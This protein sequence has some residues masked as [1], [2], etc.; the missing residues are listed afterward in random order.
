MDSFSLLRTNVALTS[1]FKIVISSDDNLY[2]ESFDSNTELSSTKYKKYNFNFDAKLETVLRNFYNNLSNEIVFGVKQSQDIQQMYNDF[3]Y[4]WDNFYSSGSS[5]VEDKS[6]SEEFEYFAPLY[7]NGTFPSNFIVFRI[8]GPG[9]IEL[10]KDN[11]K[12][13]IVDKLKCVKVFDLSSYSNIGK[14]LENNYTLNPSFPIAPIEID[15]RQ[16]EFTKWN[17]ID[18]YSGG[19]TSK[20]LFLDDFLKVNNGLYKFDKFLT[21]GW[22]NNGVVF[23][24]IL[25]LKYLFDDTPATPATVR[26]WSMNRYMGFYINDMEEVMNVTPFNSDKLSMD[27]VIGDNNY[28]INS[29][30]DYIDPILGGYNPTKTYWVEQNGQFYQIKKESIGWKVNSNISL[31]GMTYSNFNQHSVIIEEGKIKW[32]PEYR[33]DSFDLDDFD[34]YDVWLVNIDDKY[35]VVK[36]NTNGEYYLNTD[37][38]FESNRNL[39]IYYINQSDPSYTTRINLY[40]FDI[41]PIIFKIYRLKFTQINDIDNDIVNTDWSRFEYELVDNVTNTNEPKLYKADISSESYPP[42]FDIFT[43]QNEN[44]SIPVSSEYLSSNELFEKDIDSDN[45]S[46]LWYKSPVF[47]KWGAMNS[48]SNYDYPYRANNYA[49]IDSYNRTTDPYQNIPDKWARNLDYFYSI[50]PD[51]DSYDFTSV[52]I[53][54][55]EN[56]VVNTNFKFDASK[57]FNS[58]GWDGDYFT[59]F[60]GKKET[61]NGVSKNTH[62]YSSI[63]KSSPKLTG[64]TLFRGLKFNIWDVAN[65]QLDENNSVKNLNL[66]PSNNFGDWKFSVLL[67]TL[68]YDIDGEFSPINNQLSWANINMWSMGVTYSTN[69]Y[70][71]YN[72]VLYK[73]NATSYTDNP[74]DNPGSLSEWSYPTTIVDQIF[75]NPNSYAAPTYINNYGW[76]LKDDN[77]WTIK[78][79]VTF[80]N[81]STYNS[82]DIVKYSNILYKCSLDG[83]GATPSFSDV[84]WITLADWWDPDISYTTGQRVLAIDGNTYIVISSISFGQNPLSNPDTW[85]KEDVQNTYWTEVPMWENKSYQINDYTFYSGGLFRSLTSDNTQIPQPYITTTDWNFLY[86]TD[87]VLDK[88]YTIGNVVKWGNRYNICLNPSTYSVSS[89]LD[90]GV[91]IYINKK[92]NNI[93]VN[94]YCNDGTLN[95]IDNSNRQETLYSLVNQKYIASNFINVINNLNHKW[96]FI[97]NLNYY[98]IDPIVGTS[99]T[100]VTKYSLSNPDTFVTLPHIITIDFPDTLEVNPLTAKYKP[101]DIGQN[102]LPV[103]SKLSNNVINSNDQLNWYTGKNLSNTIEYIEDTDDS[104]DLY[105]GMRNN[106]YTIIWRYSGYYSPIL[107][108]VDLFKRSTIDDTRVGNYQFD[109]TLSG[110]GNLDERLY[111]KVNVSGSVLKLDGTTY[112]SSYPQVDEYGLGFSN[113]FIF[114]STWDK[115][116]YYQINK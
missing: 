59:Y 80:S 75:W 3:K 99:S 54:D 105:H 2:L 34:N 78:Q 14:F 19:W 9:I 35:H 38:G 39:F 68:K 116:Y 111:S 28:F 21:D 74:I 41:S 17:G 33:N 43:Y 47:S 55:I 12:T 8:D 87:E 92:W 24:N 31:L 44:V 69:S 40:D 86:S 106:R 65:I 79:W 25:N 95:G 56:N 89:T 114:K 91:N 72:G 13:E 5:H 112:K 94:I 64:T 104:V 22:R 37:Y 51:K 73:N 45:L 61:I 98:I 84:N 48:I 97:N 110:F 26:K 71:L 16:L 42:S 53:S 63:S 58:N 85:Q 77:Y 103:G 90:N 70:V 1:N 67:S 23:P 107:K 49:V 109:T 60:F 96:G 52:H 88:Q 57:Y 11:F 6:Y 32:N 76:V 15:Y 4:Q 62:K 7:Y 30:G 66:N 113:Y 27:I 20:S 29:S 36:K 93:L 102:V 50:N 82:D 10:T 46:S 83:Y 101:Y 100:S 18:I 108:E 81:I 115:S